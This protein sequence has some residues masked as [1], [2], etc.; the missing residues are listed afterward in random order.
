MRHCVC[1]FVLVASSAGC[2]WTRY[3]DI[4]ENA[5]IVLLNRPKA[6]SDGFGSSLATATVGESVTLL[7]GGAPLESGGAE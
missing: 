7:V 4:A 1:V 5:P 2:S 6:V 3:D